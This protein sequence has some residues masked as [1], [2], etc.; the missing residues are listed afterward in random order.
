MTP[1]T[2]YD[3]AREAN[4][5]VST[6]SRVLNDTAPVRASTREKIMSIIEKHQFQPN[7]L[8]RSLIKKETGTIAIILPDIT[9][10]FFPEVF[11]GAENEAR[12][13]GYTFFLCNTAGDHGR[14]SEYLSILREKRVDGIIFLGGRINLQ[15]C[16]EEMAQE[17]IEMGKRQPI[18]LVNGNLAR[19]GFHR[20]YTDEAAGAMQAAEHLLTLGHREIAFVGGLQKMSTTMVK[21]K[22][23]QKK[24]QEYGLEIPK[25]RLRLGSFSIDDGKRLMSEL[26][27]QD[28]PPTAVICVNDYTAIGAIKAAIN[29]GLSIPNDISIVGFDDTP[30]ASAVIPELTTVSQN[31]YQLG[32]LAVDVLHELINQGKPRKQTILQPQLVVRQSTGP[33]SR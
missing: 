24:L 12:G 29:H 5:S 27:E 10:P 11:W 25:E 33:V 30:L 17:L 8:A 13:L 2:I 32:K 20:V 4:V 7:A 22:A 1:I 21:V 28:N 16:P 26:L 6:V 3:I 19:S 15:N 9:N 18:V 23:V 31:T 14:E